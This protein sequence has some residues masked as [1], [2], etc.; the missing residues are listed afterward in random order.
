M[1]SFGPGTVGPESL[2]CLHIFDLVRPCCVFSLVRNK[3]AIKAVLMKSIN[4][5]LG[6]NVH[7]CVL[8]PRFG[9][10]STCSH[11]I[12]VIAVT[13]TQ[14][15]ATFP[16]PH[17]RD[18]LGVRERRLPVCVHALVYARVFVCLIWLVGAS[19]SA[20]PSVLS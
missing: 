7:F 6:Q 18:C 11:L 17:D 3:N 4:N 12:P 5:K 19:H 9:I 8:R 10:L 16:Q 13:G 14:I 20:C 2:F 15:P 1:R